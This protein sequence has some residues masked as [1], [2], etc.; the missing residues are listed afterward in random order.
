M[1]DLDT[2][3]EF[4]ADAAAEA[5]KR[6]KV[7]YLMETSDVGNIDSL[8]RIPNLGTYLPKGWERVDATSFGHDNG[9]G[10]GSVDDVPYYF[11]DKTGWGGE[12]EPVYPEKRRA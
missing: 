6:K 9:S 4:Q 8:K 1:M 10:A 3:R 7:P 11:V 5:A 12:G 2:I